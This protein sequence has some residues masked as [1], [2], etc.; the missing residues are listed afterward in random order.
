[1][2]YKRINERGNEART[3]GDMMSKNTDSFDRICGNCAGIDIIT[4]TEDDLRQQAAIYGA[5]EDE[6]QEALAGLEEYKAEQR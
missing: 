4:I 5:S 6:I 1:M 3:K 2:G